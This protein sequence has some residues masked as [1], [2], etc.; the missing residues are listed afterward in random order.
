MSGERTNTV[1]VVGVHTQ[2]T[3]SGQFV[4]LVRARSCGTHSGHTDGTHTWPISVGSH[5]VLDSELLHNK[6]PPLDMFLLK[7][8]PW[9]VVSSRERALGTHAPSFC[10]QRLT[11]S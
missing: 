4:R 10:P 9:R 8:E 2:A 3:L 11:T 1:H 7:S 6:E 5:E